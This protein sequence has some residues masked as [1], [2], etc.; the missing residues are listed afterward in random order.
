MN[1][2]K[3]QRYLIRWEPQKPN[4]ILEAC[5]SN[6]WR[7]LNPKYVFNL[8]N[9][10]DNIWNIYIYI[11]NEQVSKIPIAYKLSIKTLLIVF[12]TQK[13]YLE[14]KMKF[15]YL[16]CECF[17]VLR[18][19]LRF[20]HFHTV[21]LTLPINEGKSFALPIR[22]IVK[23]IGIQKHSCY[24]K[25]IS[26]NHHILQVLSST[27][28]VFFEHWN[29]LA[30]GGWFLTAPLTLNGLGKWVSYSKLRTRPSGEKFEHHICQHKNVQ[31]IGS[32]H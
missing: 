12:T 25:I 29:A 28:L 11:E 8:M 2:H 16:L 20:V 19:K 1:S 5:R 6:D 31:S 3:L 27:I 26:I 10:H 17:F 9:D 13:D 23:K 18:L 32:L 15:Y 4:I 21:L 30:K 24:S 22:W 7:L 14:I